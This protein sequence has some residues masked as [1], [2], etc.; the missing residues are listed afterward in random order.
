M[1]TILVT[2]DYNV[3]QRVM[4]HILRRYG[5][6]VLVAAHGLDALECLEQHTID[7]LLLDISMPEMDGLTLLKHLRA[8]PQYVN[9]PVVM[10]TASGQDTD[11]RNAE[12][13]GA[14]GFLSKP[15]GSAELLDMVRTVLGEQ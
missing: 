2:D 9:L 11:R 13:L 7:L 12:E 4:G 8:S 14:N 15:I 3:T 5:Y 1:A 6:D 10:L